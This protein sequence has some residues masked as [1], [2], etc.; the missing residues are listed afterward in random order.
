MT[1]YTSGQLKLN[2]NISSHFDRSLDVYG[3]KLVASGAVGG[4]EAV[5]N[6]WVYKTA[7]VVQL[8]LDK[9]ASGI[10]QAAQERA[11]GILSGAEGTF[12]TGVP[13][14][15]RISYGGGDSYS[16]NPL[17]DDG[18]LLWEGLEAFTDSHAVDDMVWYRNVSSPNPP[19]GDNDIGELM[20]HILHT[21]QTF[22]LRGAADGSLAALNPN[23]SDSKLQ[24]ALREAVD[25]GT[26]G[27]DGYGGSLDRDPEYTS[28][29]IVKEYLY[30]LTFGMWGYSTF[31]ENE[32]LAPE[33]SDAARTPEGVLQSNPLG[34]SLFNDYIAPVLS[35]PDIVT[36]RS[37]FRDNDQGESGYIWDTTESALIDVIVD[38]GVL[39]DAAVMLKNLSETMLMNGENLLSQAIEYQGQEF[40]YDN[41][42]SLIT[43]VTKNG[44]FTSEFQS[45]IEESFPEYSSL[46]Y[47]DAIGLV[48]IS[49]IDDVLLSVA[50]IDGTFVS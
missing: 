46:S 37:I 7:R 3:I 16:P 44:A 21:I 8:L 18:R 4:N 6:E 9:E 28:S 39:G 43:I 34:Y 48:G 20:E 13:T 10:D 15:Q 33:W 25:S 17:S 27:L 12:H 22:G 32:T 5:P 30:L 41:I 14:A 1:V 23:D 35:K 49:G 45:E 36:L 11:I 24:L 42:A 47:Q 19:Q 29:V 2:N 38:R 50:G 31:W 40:I 26:F